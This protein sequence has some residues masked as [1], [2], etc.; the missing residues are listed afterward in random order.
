MK[1]VCTIKTAKLGFKFIWHS[2]VPDS[3]ITYMNSFSLLAFPVWDIVDQS[4]SVC[5]TRSSI[6]FLGSP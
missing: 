4:T 1:G 3:G 2:I 5:K 6:K